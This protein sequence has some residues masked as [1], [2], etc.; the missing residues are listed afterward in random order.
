MGFLGE[1][2][3]FNSLIYL[4]IL[5]CWLVMNYSV[6]FIFKKKKQIR[7]LSRRRILYYDRKRLNCLRRDTRNFDIVLEVFIFC[8]W[9]FYHRFIPLSIFGS[10]WLF[11]GIHRLAFAEN[12]G[13]KRRAAL[14][15]APTDRIANTPRVRYK[16][17]R[18]PPIRCFN[19]RMCTLCRYGK[20]TKN[21]NTQ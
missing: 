7:L 18:C 5:I 8:R 15:S 21:K 19:C 14:H 12:V 4:V 6:H 9:I 11:T 3:K 17:C 16:T 10:V 13:P 20:R 2:S 1:L